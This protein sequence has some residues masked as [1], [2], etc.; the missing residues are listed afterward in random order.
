MR[1]KTCCSLRCLAMTTCS[2]GTNAAASRRSPGLQT[3]A[4]S[5]DSRKSATASTQSVQHERLTV[6]DAEALALRNNPQIS[7]YRACWPWP[8]S[9][10]RARPSRTTTPP[11]TAA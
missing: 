1:S 5:T 2:S 6:Q 10:S 4:Y 11:R 8:R 9:R 7:V 3:P